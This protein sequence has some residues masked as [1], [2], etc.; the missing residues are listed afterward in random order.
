VTVRAR[1]ALSPSA[2]LTIAQARLA[3]ANHA[4]APAHAALLLLDTGTTRADATDKLRQDLA[5]LGITVAGE[6]RQSTRAA[7]YAAPVEK[8]QQSGRLYPCFENPDELRVKQERAIQA[9]RKPIYNR[10]MLKLTPGQRATAESKG[11]R[12]HWR[13]LLT[14]TSESDPILIAADGTLHPT[15]TVALDDIALG[16]THLVR[17][18]DEELT[19]AIQQDI[20]A[21]LRAKPLAITHIKPLTQKGARARDIG[22]ITIRKLRQDGIE[23]AALVA[24]LTEDAEWDTEALLRRNRAILATLDYEAVAARLPA[25]ITA[26]DWT[27]LRGRIDLLSEASDAPG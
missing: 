20:R 14:D 8:L 15:L 7:T 5:W 23:P 26:E 13:F 27:R 4:L 25:G 1:L 18:T 21:A 12:P 11:K 3:L 2:P 10:A 19:S 17:T 6:H 9:G 24:T 16:T 22:K